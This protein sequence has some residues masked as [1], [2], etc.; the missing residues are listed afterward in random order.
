MPLFATLSINAKQSLH[1]FV[2]STILLSRIFD[3]MLSVVML[4]DIVMGV[5]APTEELKFELSHL[6][7]LHFD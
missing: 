7:H 5:V 4:N 3:V 2:W 1:Q 6:L